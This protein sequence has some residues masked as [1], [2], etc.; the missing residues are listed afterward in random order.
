MTQQ[1]AAKMLWNYFYEWIPS[2]IQPN[3]LIAMFRCMDGKLILPTE[4]FEHELQ[5]HRDWLIGK[6]FRWVY[7]RLPMGAHYL[8]ED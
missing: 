2:K 8:N 4:S 3:E 5:Q 1:Q 6:D 7:H